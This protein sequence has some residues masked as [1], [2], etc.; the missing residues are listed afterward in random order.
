ML[1]EIV[2]AVAW[3]TRMD[4]LVRRWLSEPP[5]PPTAPEEKGASKVDCGGGARVC[6]RGASEVGR[7]RGGLSVEERAR[8]RR[9]MEC[10][11]EGAREVEKEQT[12]CSVEDY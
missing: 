6:G 4:V 8:R 9:E 5:T 1:P 7:G 2:L 10:G 12:R 11:G 3:T